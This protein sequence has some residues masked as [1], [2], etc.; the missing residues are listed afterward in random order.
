MAEPRV[1]F[2][3]PQEKRSF[4]ENANKF[5]PTPPT[6]GGKP[7]G[8][9]AHGDPIGAFANTAKKEEAEISNKTFMETIMKATET[10]ARHTTDMSYPPPTETQSWVQTLDAV[11]AEDVLHGRE[12]SDDQI[13]D[14]LGLRSDFNLELIRSDPNFFEKNPAA[15]ARM[16]ALAQEH[17]QSQDKKAEDDNWWGMD[18]LNYVK[19]ELLDAAIT[20]G[21][22][23]D[24]IWKPA[25][26]S[27]EK[28][29]KWFPEDAEGTR[30]LLG[31]I[32]SY[33]PTMMNEDGS[34]RFVSRKEIAREIHEAMA[35]LPVG[36][37]EEREKYTA[38]VEVL[39]AEGMMGSDA[40]AQAFEERQDIP[41]YV[42]FGVDVLSDPTT[43]IGVGGLAKTVGRGAINVGK[44]F[45]AGAKGASLPFRGGEA[46]KAVL[47]PFVET[48]RILVNTPEEMGKILE[49]VRRNPAGLSKLPAALIN[50]IDPSK[51]LNKL[52]EG[53]RDYAIIALKV[54]G[55]HGD[56]QGKRM[57]EFIS[58]QMEGAHG[59][60]E[61]L[62]GKSILEKGKPTI[63]LAKK[64]EGGRIRKHAF[65]DV[66]ENADKYE[67]SVLQRTYIDDITGVYDDFKRIAREEG[68][69]MNFLG[70]L[71]EAFKYSARRVI[72]KDGKLTAELVDAEGLTWAVKH[73]AAVG[74]GLNKPRII[75]MMEE[76]IELG[77]MYANPTETLSMYAQG[78]YRDLNLHRLKKFA[79]EFPVEGG[80]GAHMRGLSAEKMFPEE[81]ANKALA[82]GVLDAQ[83]KYLEE[84]TKF[85]HTGGE[86]MNPQTVNAM[87]RAFAD[88]TGDSV[89]VLA[90]KKEIRESV[91]SLLR[92]RQNNWQKGIRA[93]F[94]LQ[95]EA[96]P[97]GLSFEALRDAIK[98]GRAGSRIYKD[99]SVKEL[100]K[101]LTGLNIGRREK[102]RLIKAMVSEMGKQVRRDRK[103]Q[104]N[105][106]VGKMNEIVPGTRKMYDKLDA[107]AQNLNRQAMNPNPMAGEVRSRLFPDRIYKD[108]KFL[109][110][111][112]FFMADGG[113]FM[114]AAADVNAALR[115]FKTT[116]DMGAPLIQGLPLL[117]TNAEAWGKATAMHIRA[118]RDPGVRYKYI[119]DNNEKINIYIKHGMH[120]GSSEMTEAAS[121]GGLFAR[122]PL[123]AAKGVRR[124]ETAAMGMGVPE[125]LVR[126]AGA[127][128]MR[129]G[130]LATAPIRYFGKGFQSSFDTYLDVARIE[131][132]KSLEPTFM[133]ANGGL[134][135]AK[136]M[137]ELAN[138]ANKMTGVTSTRAMGV[139]VGQRNLEQAILMFS[140]RY[141]R[142]TAA[143]FMDMS[144]G[145]IRGHQAR[146]AVAG[147][148]AGQV[149]L[150]AA[151]TT[152]LGQEMNLMPGQGDFLKVRLG[153]T[154]VGFGGKP[155]S[156]MNMAVDLAE[157]GIDPDQRE[158]FMDWKAWSADTYNSNSFMKRIRWQMAPV[159]GEAINWI[160]GTDPIGRTLPDA[161][162]IITN[163]S[164]ALE[165]AGQ[166]TFPFWLDAVYEGGHFDFSAQASIGEFGGAAA[167]PVLPHIKL[168]ELRDELVEK[169]YGASHNL[170]SYDDLKKSNTFGS[171]YAYLTQTY[172]ELQTAED[173]YKEVQGKFENNKQ[174][175]LF[176]DEKSRIRGDLIEGIVETQPTGERVVTQRGY[177]QISAE[178]ESGAHGRRAGFMFRQAL[179]AANDQ[180]DAR[181]AD[182]RK[183]FPKLVSEGK[184][185]W[186]G[187][188]QTNETIA[189]TNEFFDFLASPDSQDVFG[190]T[191]HLAIAR[192][193]Q[194][195]ETKYGSEVADEMRN[196]YVRKLTQTPDGVVMPE[197]VLDYYESWDTL[198]PFW[199]AYLD[200]FKD[201]STREDWRIFKNSNPGQ[202]A[203]LEQNPKYAKMKERVVFH[204]D[205]MRRGNYEI[206]KALTIFYDMASKNPKRER[207]IKALARQMR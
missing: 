147:L 92:F 200:V 84:L 144:T 15:K 197:I 80:A 33:T 198:E 186:T 13:R 121:K 21:E 74:R 129:G 170:H 91:D 202:Q 10:K 51:M 85:M 181:T 191:N 150:H 113:G 203:L 102:D 41:G 87:K 60:I 118:F 177:R 184:E 94:D 164:K 132:M 175:L 182:L 151:A 62:F 29:A 190:N 137:T 98:G 35:E 159:G 5:G 204:Q 206:D 82:K 168:E 193:K 6:T 54:V 9:G 50:K 136:S 130:S 40:S 43:Y 117:F 152:A 42:K 141:T 65:G 77:Y 124:G 89:E 48:K 128:V 78:F 24:L 36:Q 192:K 104:L 16:E 125:G 199:N 205:K 100:R 139:S 110:V 66:F 90:T 7:K 56:E 207:E 172:P 97:P 86:G 4:R 142:A 25:D 44:G 88:A 68:M 127:G 120:L 26:W 171:K 95:N 72:G 160:T 32:L 108:S 3:R 70:E 79:D 166:K 161:E 148:F 126:G 180:S 64:G 58:Q 38:R 155:N 59:K 93:V 103:S 27:N 67:L 167:N 8:I 174:R 153:D 39:K 31:N 123:M 73:A 116:F 112:E 122:L 109:E 134:N 119:F 201:E 195:I 20:L 12:F 162:D 106:L 55:A 165:Y 131:I 156:L 135:Q 111:D 69:E 194:Q 30:K 52:K 47:A 81:F 63:L 96:I 185:Y 61:T 115:M 34:P 107:D 133:A 105:A 187:D 158:G 49:E 45:Q 114:K 189:A 99:I 154:M 75:E 14:K 188:G 146:K 18:A 17:L 157:Q 1:W 176:Q 138:F 46:T 76:G 57:A 169:E 53:T 22:A 28:M 140:P 183:R 11:Q 83:S 145:G 37:E 163:P 101:A 143:L 179:R 71:S 149:A 178:F 23:F 173:R 19:D 196:N 2:N